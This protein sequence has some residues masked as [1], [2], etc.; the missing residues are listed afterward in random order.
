MLTN[1]LSPV[2]FYNNKH[3]NITTEGVSVLSHLAD[4]SADAL[5]F[6]KGLQIT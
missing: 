6:M 5:T 1:A 2:L 3:G 4:N